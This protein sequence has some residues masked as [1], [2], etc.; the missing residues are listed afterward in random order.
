MWKGRE[1]VNK[2]PAGS[3]PV[4]KDDCLPVPLDSVMWRYLVTFKGEISA[5]REGRGK[6]IKV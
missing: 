4:E 1:R 3:K 6:I 2:E 5:E